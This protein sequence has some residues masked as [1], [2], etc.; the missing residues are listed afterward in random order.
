MKKNRTGTFLIRLLHWEYWPFHFVYG[1]IYIYWFVLC[2]R[3]RSLFFFNAANPTIRNGGFLLES[4]KE[5]YDIIPGDW[6]PPTLF[7]QQGTHA[8][9]I[10]A[11]LKESGLTYPLIGKPDI[12]MRG[13]GV[14]KLYT[15]E[16]VLAYA[17]KSRVD[18]LLQEFI[19]FEK[20]VGI[21]YYRYPNSAKGHIS[22]IVGKEFLTVTGDGVSTIETL[23]QKDQRYVLQMASLQETKGEELQEILSKHENRIL[24]PYGNHARGAKF[25]DLSN[26]IDEK[27]SATI[28]KISQHIPGFY[29][30]RMDIRYKDWESLKNGIDFSIIE[31]NGAGSEPTHIYDP[32][33]SIFFAWKEIIR[34][35]HILLTISRQN[36]QQKKIPF[37]PFTAGCKM[38]RENSAY[39]KKLTGSV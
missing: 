15:Q 7:F 1:P 10:A 6:Y 5:I 33:H 35:W 32:G 24:V 19:P 18:F 17:N 11:R 23:L 38:L 31:L 25:I 8:E 22:G 27:L 20:E 30:G 13:L 16:E 28:D 21:F 39:V 14:E 9:A 3:A 2:M 37:L 12:G 26:L 29:F 34:H 4:K 36:H